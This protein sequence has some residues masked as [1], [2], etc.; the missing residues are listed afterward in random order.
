M[1]KESLPLRLRAY[2]TTDASVIPELN[3]IQ[4]VPRPE[5]AREN[6]PQRRQD[7][8]QSTKGLKRKIAKAALPQSQNVN[9]PAHF[10]ASTPS[11]SRESPS[12]L[13][14]VSDS[15][16]GNNIGI[17]LGSPSMRPPDRSWLALSPPNFPGEKHIKDDDHLKRKPSK[18]KKFGGLFKSKS[19]EAMPRMPFYE[20][21]VNDQQ[22][23]AVNSSEYVPDMKL[24]RKKPVI[25][26]VHAWPARSQS[27]PRPEDL[28]SATIS[29][30][31]EHLDSGKPASV[32]EASEGQRHWGSWSEE[33]GVIQQTPSGSNNPHTPLLNVDIPDVELERYSVMFGAFYDRPPRSN[34]LARRSKNLDRIKPP[35]ALQLGRQ[36]D[37][38]RPR[39]AT[40]PNSTRSPSFTLFPSTPTNKAARLLGSH[41]L[42]R[43]PTPLQKS[44]TMPASPG[45]VHFERN[46]GIRLGH[47]PVGTSESSLSGWGSVS[48]QSTAPSELCDDDIESS[49]E[50]H[51]TIR[52]CIKPPEQEEPTWEMVTPGRKTFPP[53]PRFKQRQTPVDHRP[54][55]PQIPKIPTTPKP[56]KSTFPAR[57][58]AFPFQDSFRLPRSPTQAPRPP[59]EPIPEQDSLHKPSLSI[60]S[61]IEDFQTVEI[62][63]ARS[64]SVSKRKRVLVPVIGKSSTALRSQERLVAKKI[65][66]P[67]SEVMHRGHRHER[68]RVALFEDA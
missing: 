51:E 40:S 1:A 55:I 19:P 59:K 2:T 4:D 46:P 6:S 16:D 38:V 27:L 39:R 42:P 65:A 31:K 63:V 3:G 37:L 23:Q 53:S 68:S 21:R 12:R 57:L 18:W 28:P 60:D 43:G 47:S 36:N 52:L 62:S 13:A 50:E 14:S 22:L 61:T 32:H 24:L 54:K 49:D 10:T 58:P 26:D 17:A 45:A 44:F 8:Q 20:V 41:C 34:L 48:L 30:E 7:T 35:S 9:L 64:V 29:K 25:H 66:T 33:P 11:L 67:T 15:W 5:S 56:A